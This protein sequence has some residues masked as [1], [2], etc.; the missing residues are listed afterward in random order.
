MPEDYQYLEGFS[1]RGNFNFDILVNGKLSDKEQPAVKFNFGLADGSIQHSE[2]GSSI[3]D[4][5]FAASFTNGTSTSGK[6][7]VF[8]IQNFKGYFNRELIESKVRVTNL[9]N[10]RIQIDL[11]GTMPIESIVPLLGMSAL[12]DGD[13]EMEFSNVH[14]D[15][16]YEDMI[17]TSRIH[18]VDATGTVSYTHLTL[19]TKA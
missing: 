1:S 6:D 19:P 11:D 4:V 2:L 14:I 16:K 10:P 3:K 12:T 13:G 18:R 15:G 17:R 5:S 9:D 8:E 7:A